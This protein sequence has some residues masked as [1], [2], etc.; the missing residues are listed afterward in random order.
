MPL[1]SASST[2]S[3][4]VVARRGHPLANSRSAGALASDEWL[5]VVRREATAEALRTLGVP[6]SK[7]I[8]EC[9]SFSAML[10]LLASS[11][12]LAVV[13]HPIL[14]M[15]SAAQHAQ[16]I[17]IAERLPGLTGGRHTAPMRR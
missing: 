12:M 17:R 11:G 4:T 3:S 16:E 2:L 15:P 13:Q 14:H 6:D 9:E 7:R 1:S 5:C 10:T 8:T